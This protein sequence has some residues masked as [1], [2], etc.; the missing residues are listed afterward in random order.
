MHSVV[1]R[2][3]LFSTL[4]LS[5]PYCPE[6]IILGCKTSNSCEMIVNPKS[7]LYVC[8]IISGAHMNILFITKVKI[9]SSVNGHIGPPRLNFVGS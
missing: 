7:C 4:D 9:L 6:A 1:P 2:S 8:L 3:D 5:G